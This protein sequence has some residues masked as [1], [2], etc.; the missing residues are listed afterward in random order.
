MPNPIIPAFDDLMNPLIDALT[1]LGGSGSIDEIENKV[2]ELLKLTDKQLEVMH[3]TTGKDTRTSFAYNLAWA[4]SY[5]GIYGVLEVSSRG[6]WA[7]T[8]KG[9]KIGKVD[10]VEVKRYVW[11]QDKKL[12]VATALGSDDVAE[13]VEEAEEETASWREEVAEA[14]SKM[15]PSGFERLIQRILRE[16]D[17]IRVEVTGRS[18]DGGVDGRG[19][20]RLGGLIGF[21]VIFQAKRWK[22]SVGAPEIRG[23]RGAMAGRADKA[24]FITTSTFTKE[25]KKEASRDG[26]LPIDLID[27][28]ELVDKL[29]LLSLGVK[30]EKK[31]V[32]KVTVVPGWFTTI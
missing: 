28:E 27:G 14:L 1:A 20:L 12:K 32:E 25:A 8:P 17:F 26:A 24:L 15:T 18:G 16:S 9:S 2:A 4:R 23:F 3:T 6:V 7:L 21:T 22:N 29:K 11:R 30:I 5:L 31:E 13:T 19:I 10:P